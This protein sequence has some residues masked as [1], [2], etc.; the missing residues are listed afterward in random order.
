M[1]RDHS[2]KY[3]NRHR[4]G[5]PMEF[6]THRAMVFDQAQASSAYA[7]GFDAMERRCPDCGA[8]C[9]G[10]DGLRAHEAK[11]HYATVTITADQLKEALRQPGAVTPEA[12]GPPAVSDNPPPCTS[13]G[14]PQASSLGEAV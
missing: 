9:L 6:E 11:S 3:G 5:W 1:R 12:G 14:E 10:E 2:K 7:A 4:P 8:R 13:R